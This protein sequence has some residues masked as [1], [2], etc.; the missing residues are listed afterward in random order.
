[1]HALLDSSSLVTTQEVSRALDYHA[2]YR[3]FGNTVVKAEIR[4]TWESVDGRLVLATNTFGLG[5][6]RPDV[7][8]VVHTQVHKRSS[9]ALV[10]PRPPSPLLER[11]CV[12]DGLARGALCPGFGRCREATLPEPREAGAAAP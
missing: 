2:Y 4:N 6:N 9:T 12:D 3:D 5:I 7:R 8:I 11:R 1:M 10:P